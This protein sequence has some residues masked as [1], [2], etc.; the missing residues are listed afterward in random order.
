VSAKDDKP[1]QKGV[2]VFNGDTVSILNKGLRDRVHAITAL[3]LTFQRF[4]YTTRNRNA[5][6]MTSGTPLLFLSVHTPFSEY[7]RQLSV[8][9]L[10]NLTRRNVIR[11]SVAYSAL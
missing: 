5:I 4:K 1:P 6:A 8:E 11:Y 2:V 10:A 3:S 9:M 7:V